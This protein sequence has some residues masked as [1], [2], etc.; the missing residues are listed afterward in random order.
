MTR[1]ALLACLL[2][3]SFL[4]ACA[5]ARANYDAYL[6]HMPRSILVLPPVN[7]T[8]DA[9]ASGAFL[10][11][12]S[13]PLAECGYY[14]YPVAVVDE[15]MKDNGLP[16]PGDMH[17]VPLEKLGEVFGADAVLYIVIKEWKT[18]YLV[19]D[20]STTVTLEYRLR[21]IKTGVE[22]WHQ[23]ITARHSSSQ[24]TNNL[25]AMLVSAAVSAI[26]KAASTPEWGVA[27]QANNAMFAD[28]RRGIP[29]G[30]R[31][32]DFAK[33]QER[34]KSERAAAAPPAPEAGSP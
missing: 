16:T 2:G 22:L 8:T 30:H 7:L 14:V 12:I 3:T 24:G 5:P 33:D 25:F 28:P 11:T 9:K 18:Q 20:T 15:L 1:A 13:S 34:L 23:Q 31:H 10:S 27:R 32:P 21:D 19:V 4:N 26:A 17:Q 29:K 6:D